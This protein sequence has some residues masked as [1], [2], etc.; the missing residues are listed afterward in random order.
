MFIIDF[1]NLSLSGATMKRQANSMVKKH[2]QNE[3]MCS[4]VGMGFDNI[5]NLIL[6]LLG[7]SMLSRGEDVD[8]L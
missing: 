1:K 7:S 3:S 4:S 5:S 2:V 8:E 6:G